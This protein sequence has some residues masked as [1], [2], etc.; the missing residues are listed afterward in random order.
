MRHGQAESNVNRIL[1][2]RQTES[3]LTEHGRKQ[4]LDSAKQLMKNIAI[5]KVYVSPVIRTVETAQIVC[6]VLG[7]DYVIDE[8]LYETEMGRLVGMNYEEIT[9]KY[10]DVL[11][12][13]YSDY[14]PL[15]E[16]F[17]V[18]AFASVK[19]RITS[20]LDDILQKHQDS[21]VLMVTHLDPIKAALATLLNL[22][23]ESLHRWNIRNASLTILKHESRIYSISGVNVMVMYRYPIE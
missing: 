10:G 18:E 8:R 17:G 19:H 1:A 4:V 2:G 12:R 13:F 22:G 14:D 7:T 16:S 3:H 20:L 5:E 6:Q 23:R 9:T 15:L 11:T 21:N